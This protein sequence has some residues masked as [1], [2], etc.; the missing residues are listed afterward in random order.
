VAGTIAPSGGDSVRA[1]NAAS[2]G[3]IIINLTAP[4][5]VTDAKALTEISIAAIFERLQL[6]QGLG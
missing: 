5:G 3:Q 1:G 2:V 4:E 6:Q